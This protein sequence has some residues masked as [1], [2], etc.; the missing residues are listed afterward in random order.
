MTEKEFFV[1]ELVIVEQNLDGSEK[2]ARFPYNVEPAV[3]G[4]ITEVIGRGRNLIFYN[5]ED[6]DGNLYNFKTTKRRGLKGRVC[7]HQRKIGWQFMGFHYQLKRVNSEELGTEFEKSLTDELGLVRRLADG[8]DETRKAAT[9]ATLRN[10]TRYLSSEIDSAYREAER[11]ARGSDETGR[12]A[13]LA[14]LRN[15]N[16]Y[17]LERQQ[18]RAPSA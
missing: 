7:D 15:L 4:K 5:I 12:A 17:L 2:R 16:T 6:V 10:L 18:S 14:T 8:Q 11:L 9:I 13:A 1:G 3:I